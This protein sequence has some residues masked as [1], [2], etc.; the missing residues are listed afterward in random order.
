MVTLHWL[1]FVLKMLQLC[2]VEEGLAQVATT[3]VSSDA[4]RRKVPL[5]GEKTPRNQGDLQRK[6]PP[7]VNR[8]QLPAKRARSGK[9]TVVW[10]RGHDL[11]VADHPAL[12]AAVRRGR[13]SLHCQSAAESVQHR[14]SHS[15]FL[16]TCFVCKRQICGASVHMGATR[17]ESRGDWTMVNT[18]PCLQYALIL[19]DHAQLTL[20][21]SDGAGQVAEAVVGAARESSERDGPDSDL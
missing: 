4:E 12:S 3:I 2:L 14:N 13:L 20:T 7:A 9:T 16:F 8:G 1:C 6:R 17:V 11:R 10:Y 15:L 5:T 18:S 19:V 21:M